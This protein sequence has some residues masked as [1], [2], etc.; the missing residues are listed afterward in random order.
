M[1]YICYVTTLDNLNVFYNLG[2]QTSHMAY[3]YRR[4]D[5][6]NLCLASPERLIKIPARLSVADESD[7]AVVC[8]PIFLEAV[9]CV[10]SPDYYS[11]INTID[12]SHLNSI[13]C[14]RKKN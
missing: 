7:I 1:L 11:K 3:F 12:I 5:T 14:L 4:I 2:S 10:L 8:D 13:R 9:N 6:P